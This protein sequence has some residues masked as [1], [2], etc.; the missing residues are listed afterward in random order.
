MGGGR[1]D[2][3]CRLDCKQGVESKGSDSNL[4]EVDGEVEAAD[5]EGGLICSD[6]P[7]R[8]SSALV[9]RGSLASIVQVVSGEG[10]CGSWY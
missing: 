8:L 5:E 2:C 9:G 7:S 3:A 6:V 1:G 4:V 10:E